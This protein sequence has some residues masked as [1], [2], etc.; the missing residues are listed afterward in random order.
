MLGSLGTKIGEGNTAEVYEWSP[1]R[2]IK[3]FKLGVPS[4]IAM[5]EA[6]MTRAAFLAGASAPEVFDEV[7][8]G[9]QTGLVMAR[10]DGKT[11]TQVTKNGEI[12]CTE[13]GSMLAGA[14]RCVH[15]TP[16]PP[17]MPLLR[18]CLCS[19]LRRAPGTL[20]DHVIT[21]ITKL[22]DRLRPG[23]GLCHGDPN[24]GNV[25]KSPD[26]PKLID[27]TAAVRAP[28]AFDVASA[29]LILTELAPLIV[30]DPKRPQA[31]YA[32]MHST[33]AALA[34]ISCGALAASA[35]PYLP[36]VRGLLLLNGAVPM[37][38]AKLV[39]DLETEFAV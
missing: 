8:I 1:G 22:M 9:G 6:R 2:V 30:D 37:H 29:Q 26:G 39:R 12:S 13:A 18:D 21:G 23:D 32:A 36:L 11:L 31:I 5:H 24:P 19:G 38:A 20:S 17:D 3:L 7:T 35:K 4:R 10:V 28:A 16:P 34:R 33:Y 14:L 25:I 15:M 27:W